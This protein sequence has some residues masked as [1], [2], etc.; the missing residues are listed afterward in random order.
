MKKKKK[1]S[2]L[3]KIGERALIIVSVIVITTVIVKATDNKLAGN[4]EGDDSPCPL[5]MVFVNN[6][7][8]GF[9]IDK[10]E[11]SA[12]L[13]CPHEDPSNQSETKDNI[14]YPECK[15]VSAAGNIPWRN[16][17]QNQA[18]IA[19]AKAGKRLPVNQEWQQ[20]S[21]A[22]PDKSSG[23]GQD[24]CQVDN[25][26]SKQPGPAGSGKNC[27][28][29]AGAFDMIGNVWEWISGSIYEGEFEG[30]VLPQSGYVASFDERG[31]PTETDNDD[32]DE[33]YNKDYFWINSNGTRG[34]SRGG[35]WSNSF[36]AGQY[37]VYAVSPPSFTGAGVGFRCAK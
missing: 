30:R 8:G 19:C 15:P 36:D 10:Y 5:E 37:S 12:G 11:A 26:W 22:T 3:Y 18:E 23:W 4:I 2:K 31:M 1:K 9:C 24:D 34:I 20:A 17:S 35:Y 32:P 14:D 27:A 25:N 29:A 6:S 28:S 7:A 33:N 16:I 21:L 13:G